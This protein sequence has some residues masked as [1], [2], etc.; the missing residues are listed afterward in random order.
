MFSARI[1]V[2]YFQFADIPQCKKDHLCFETS[3]TLASDSYLGY[4]DV[5]AENIWQIRSTAPQYIELSIEDFDVGCNTG[6]LFQVELTENTLQSFCN[7]D[8]P[9]NRIVSISNHMTIKFKQNRIL[10][11]LL[12]QFIGHYQVE[13]MVESTIHIP[14]TFEEGRLKSCYISKTC[15]CSIQSSFSAVKIKTHHWKKFDFC[16]NFAKKKRY[17]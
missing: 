8:K 17:K 16:N 3:A 13:Q 12:E 10:G 9:I 6:S 15:P 2:F 4:T 14:A 1:T 11:T 7:T 5:D